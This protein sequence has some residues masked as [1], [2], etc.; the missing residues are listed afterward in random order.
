M[1]A[2][3]ITWTG[4][5]AIV[6]SAGPV[7]PA[8]RA[9]DPGADPRP[10]VAAPDAGR[11]GNDGDRAGRREHMRKRCQELVKK[12][13]TDG[14]GKLSPAEREAA[15]ES[16][17][18]H[19]KDSP[20]GQK[21]LEKFDANG[22]GKLDDQEWAAARAALKKHFSAGGGPG[23][24]GGDGKDKLEHLLQGKHGQ[25]ILDRFDANHDGVLDDEER[26]RALEEFKARRQEM[27]KKF[28][29]DGDGKLS[30]EERAAAR[31]AMKGQRKGGGGG[32]KGRGQQL[33]KD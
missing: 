30:P 6:L 31:E 24:G 18:D 25:Q 28:D 12:F 7:A 16:V 14:D 2:R 15:I 26:A 8:A 22:D 20:M 9:E 33:P 23:G 21:L 19:I 11:G 13:D 27:L 3:L 1:N 4:L 5:L 10:G 17:R 32:G 29:T